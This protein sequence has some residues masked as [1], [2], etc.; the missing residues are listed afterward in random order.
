MQSYVNLFLSQM[1]SPSAVIEA[2]SGG[3]FAAIIR[4][5][6]DLPLNLVPLLQ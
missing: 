5:G 3:R 6:G 4:S 1:R 2:S